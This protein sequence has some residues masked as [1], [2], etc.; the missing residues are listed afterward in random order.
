MDKLRL[1]STWTFRNPTKIFEKAFR[2]RRSPLIESKFHSS[3]VP[4]PAQ[5]PASAPLEY[6]AWLDKLIPL[7]SANL[8]VIKAVNGKSCI[9]ENP[10]VTLSNEYLGEFSFM[11]NK[12][13]IER[14]LYTYP[15]KESKKL[16]GV[17]SGNG[18][19]KT[20]LLE[21][22]RQRLNEISYN[23]V[24]SVTF[25]NN[26]MYDRKNEMFIEGK[27]SL[28]LN[29]MM[30][31]LIRVYNIVFDTADGIKIVKSHVGTLD[32]SLLTNYSHLVE[33]FRYAMDRF[34]RAINESNGI[35]LK[36][37]VLM[38]DD[39]MKLAETGELESKK[40]V[41]EAFHKLMYCLTEAILN[42][43]IL[44]NDLNLKATLIISSLELL[45][46]H[47]TFNR[48]GFLMLES[49]RIVARDVFDKWWLSK[50]IDCNLSDRY[51]LEHMASTLL[52]V[53]RLLEFAKKYIDEKLIRSNEI[54]LDKESIHGLYEEIF[55]MTKE[56]YV[57]IQTSV[58]ASRKY[59]LI[60]QEWIIFNSSMD[61]LP[62]RRSYFSGSTPWVEGNDF[63]PQ[64]SLFMLA[65]N[66]VANDSTMNLDVI[67]YN[68]P[69]KIFVNT[70]KSLLKSIVSGS[71]T[72]GLKAIGTSWLIARLV[73]SRQNGNM[74]VSAQKLLGFQSNE[75]IPP[76]ATPNIVSQGSKYYFSSD[77]LPVICNK[78]RQSFAMEFNNL[79]KV[80]DENPCVIVESKPGQLF[81]TMLVSYVN[82]EAYVLII[83]FKSNCQMRADLNEKSSPQLERIAIDTTQF[84]EWQ[85]TV[86]EFSKLSQEHNTVKLSPASQAL[87]DGRYKFVYMTT[88][89]LV[90]QPV[91]GSQVYVAEQIETEYFMSIF[92]NLYSR[93]EEK[94]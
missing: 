2:S 30:S 22:C 34:V 27:N 80:S 88:H 13:R 24:I 26:S 36:V 70:L 79:I 72:D 41:I 81:D 65:A 8:N 60:F 49:P 32:P 75:G 46:F 78:S 31:L 50:N 59:A 61:K 12:Y 92:W 91:N 10:E 84:D 66:E 68:D 38:I 9:I 3:L 18:G 86:A 20:R 25:N 37:I 6:R 14:Y 44:N 42:S 23:L 71:K 47:R 19:G 89:P 56:N 52:G 4:D 15:G 55:K 62:F 67:D 28:E 21:E 94:I 90:E 45:P 83:D 17:S 43:F 54:K 35:R 85:S 58:D 82:G 63:I 87:V 5:Q 69:S 39:I 74:N 33:M 1:V 7:K 64:G 29:M 77:L 51:R 48:W 11:R 57:D 40:E 73:A 16:I 53:P 76:I 93:R